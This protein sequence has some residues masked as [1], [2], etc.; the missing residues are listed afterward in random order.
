MINKAVNHSCKMY[1]RANR[2]VSINVIS[3]NVVRSF[4]VRQSRGGN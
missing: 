2:A 4:A 3:D 1:I